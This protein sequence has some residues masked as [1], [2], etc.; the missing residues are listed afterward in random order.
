[1]DEIIRNIGQR[2]TPKIGGTSKKAHT[3][4]TSIPFLGSGL[5]AGLGTNI[6]YFQ[7]IKMRTYFPSQYFSGPAFLPRLHNLLQ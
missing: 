1:M 2:E 6:N 7:R 5:E 4:H 3:K